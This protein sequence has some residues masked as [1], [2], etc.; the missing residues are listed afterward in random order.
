MDKS[1]DER[2]LDLRTL[3]RSRL[4]RDLRLIADLLVQQKELTT[5]EALDELHHVY[6]HY[7]IQNALL[8]NAGSAIHRSDRKIQED[9]K[10]LRSID[11]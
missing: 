9:L 10:R 3:V 8:D 7:L 5:T 1:N 11:S 2:L 6:T 4:E